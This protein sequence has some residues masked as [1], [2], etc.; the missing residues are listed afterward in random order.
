MKLFDHTIKIKPDL[1]SAYLSG[2]YVPSKTE[3]KTVFEDDSNDN[4]DKTSVLESLL[5]D[6]GSK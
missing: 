3:Q 6:V 2:I 1:D 5:C 4:I